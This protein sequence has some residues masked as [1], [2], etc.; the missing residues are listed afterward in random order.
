MSISDFINKKFYQL[1]KEHLL[2]NYLKTNVHGYFPTYALSLCE[3]SYQPN[4]Q[5]WDLCCQVIKTA[6]EKNLDDIAIRFDN[7]LAKYISTYPGEHYKLLASVIDI[8]AP[9]LV[10][11][12]GTDRGASS[13]VMKKFLPK[14]SKIITYDIIPWNKIMNTGFSENDFDCM[15]EQKIMDISKKENYLLE[16]KIISKADFIFVDAAKDGIM[17]RLLCS[18]FDNTQFEKPPIVLFDDIKFM[19]MIQIWGE[20]KHPKIDLTSFGHWSGTG[21]VL[22]S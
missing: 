7:D 13:L 15:L 9:R 16:S 5:L 11:E 6:Y 8:L 1:K 4:K 3:D 17:E 20:I 18:F 10:I 14:N 22:W 21:I 2:K 19:E 12:I